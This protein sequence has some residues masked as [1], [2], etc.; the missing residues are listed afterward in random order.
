[1]NLFKILLF[2]L[3]LA[4]VSCAKKSSSN[5]EEDLSETVVLTDEVDDEL[6]ELEGVEVVEDSNGEEVLDEVEDIAMAETPEEVNGTMG[7]NEVVIE[8]TM[9]S[10]PA[11]SL[12]GSM[13]TYTVEKND[14]LMWIAFKVYGDYRMWKKIVMANPGLSAST[15]KSGMTIKYNT[16]SKK[17]N[18]QPSG[19]P[20]LILS[21]DTLGLISNKVYGTQKRW[22]SIWDNNRPMIRNPNLIFAGF[23]LYYVPEKVALNK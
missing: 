14:T 22:K 7:G 18:W 4:L 3:A 20:Y 6:D 23:T 1:M 12:S 10:T 8:D 11:V 15:L 13:S 9:D 17:F 5:S 19:N 21:G 16:P 2:T